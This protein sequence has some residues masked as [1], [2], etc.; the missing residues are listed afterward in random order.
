MGGVGEHLVGKVE[1][2]G[3]E[4]V[5]GWGHRERRVGSEERGGSVG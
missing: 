2:R 4:G 5:R 3:G 1:G